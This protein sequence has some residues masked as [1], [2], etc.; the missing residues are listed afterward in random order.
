MSDSNENQAPAGAP[1]QAPEGQGPG[2]IPKN[3]FDEVI[4][5]RDSWKEQAESHKAKAGEAQTLAARIAELEATHAKAAAS[6]AEERAFIASGLGG[7]QE[8]MD[9]ARF[10]YSRLPDTAE[11]PRPELGAWLAEIKADPTKAPRALHGYLQAPA[12]A[13]P[14]GPAVPKPVVGTGRPPA[15]DGGVNAQAIREATAQAQ[16]SGD[17]STFDALTAAFEKSRR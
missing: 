16:R 12:P 3:R 2:W 8:A 17:W 4:A 9:V 5:Q 15:T 7:D 6:W 10:A 1:S 11:A 13:A 14:T